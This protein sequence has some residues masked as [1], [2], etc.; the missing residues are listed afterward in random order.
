MVGAEGR[1]IVYVDIVSGA[2]GS[3]IYQVQDHN[4]FHQPLNASLSLRKSLT[5][6]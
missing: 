1:A 2:V 6:S 5:A 4:R 3:L